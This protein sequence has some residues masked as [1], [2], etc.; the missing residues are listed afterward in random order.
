MWEHDPTDPD[1][2]MDKVVRPFWLALRGFLIVGWTMLR[3]FG[4][5]RARLFRCPLCHI[6]LK[7]HE[8]RCPACGCKIRWLW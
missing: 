8:E 1:V 4:R 6:V 7:P 2:G 5:R 3:N